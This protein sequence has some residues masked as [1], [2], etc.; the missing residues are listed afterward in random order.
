M[1]H[2]NLLG[3]MYT[4]KE[5]FR[6]QEYIFQFKKVAESKRATLPSSGTVLMGAD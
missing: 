5:K 4:E 2:N 6:S 3:F 1:Y